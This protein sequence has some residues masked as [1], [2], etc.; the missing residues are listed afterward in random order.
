MSRRSIYFSTFSSVRINFSETAYRHL[1]CVCREVNYQHN[2]STKEKACHEMH[3]N[4][5]KIVH[6][7]FEE[8][9]MIAKA[10]IVENVHLCISLRE[11]LKIPHRD[12]INR[13]KKY[14]SRNAP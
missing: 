6:A 2:Y 1:I 13:L 3:S 4:S 14:A 7:N 5:A 8:C 10:R 11:M 9:A 12:A